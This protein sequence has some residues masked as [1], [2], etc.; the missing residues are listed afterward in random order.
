[1]LVWADRPGGVCLLLLGRFEFECLAGN[2]ERLLPASKVRLRG[3]SLSLFGGLGYVTFL[4]PL[5]FS[6]A[7]SVAFVRFLDGQK[8]INRRRLGSGRS[9]GSA[10]GYWA[11][12]GRASGG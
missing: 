3:P 12:G 7:G 2:S 6:F 11:G 4:L 8:D 1:M 9:G 5:S 10:D